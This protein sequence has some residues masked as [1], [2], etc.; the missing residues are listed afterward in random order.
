[1][2]FNV[3][4]SEK[5]PPKEDENRGKTSNENKIYWPTAVGYWTTAAYWTTP[6]ASTLIAHEHSAKEDEKTR[7]NQ[8][9]KG[10]TLA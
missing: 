3:D 7:G 10:Y 6:V 4:H 2:S 5:N 1:M 8:T 9:K